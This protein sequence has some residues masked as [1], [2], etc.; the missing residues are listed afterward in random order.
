MQ[1]ISVP[2]CTKKFSELTGGQLCVL[3]RDLRDPQKPPETI[4]KMQSDSQGFNAILENWEGESANWGR[5]HVSDD[6]DIVEVR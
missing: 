5:I 6:E 2:V 1:I 4:R 3:V